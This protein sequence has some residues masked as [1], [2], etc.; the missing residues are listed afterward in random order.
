MKA[1]TYNIRYGL[2]LD[3]RYDLERIANAVRDADII[4]LQEVERFWRRS[5]M[6][7]QPE[8]LGELLPDYYR[9]YC[10]SLDV[11]ASTRD[12]NG[13][14]INRRRQFGLMLLSKRP[15]ISA[16]MIALPQLETVDFF[17]RVNLSISGAIEVVTATPAGVLRVYSLHLSSVSSRERLLQID[18]LLN[19]FAYSKRN[20][21]TV[22]RNDMPTD[23]IEA[24]NF[25]RMNWSNDEATPP[26]PEHTLF[27]GDFN[28][29]EESPEY[30]RFA[31]EI[32]P[33]YG[34]GMH[35]DDLIDSWSVAKE[36]IG[37]PTSWWPDPPD[38]APGK[39]LRLDYCFVSM[40]LASK[41]SRAW[42]DVDADGSD[43]KPYWVEFNV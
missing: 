4:S 3:N 10:P 28:S 11:D 20:R 19:M 37:H 12:A 25:V 9:V 16:R 8:R 13:G 5:G 2:G 14:I 34:R 1:V 26:A 7:D 29:L 22:S 32:D 23:P 42:V 36:T 39:A 38:R 30:I 15:V 18:T 43:H 40:G 27:M 17:S 33:V 31:G 24:K 35:S 6:T 41:V 21:A